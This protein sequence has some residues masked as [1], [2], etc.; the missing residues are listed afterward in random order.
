MLAI[1]LSHEHCNE[2]LIGNVSHVYHWK[3]NF[4]YIALK[5]HVVHFMAITRFLRCIFGY[6]QM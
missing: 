3:K 5:R 2:I 1:L 4:F 6:G